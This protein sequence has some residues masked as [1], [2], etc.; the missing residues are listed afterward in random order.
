MLNTF[1]DLDICYILD[2]LGFEPNQIGAV[3]GSSSIPLLCLQ[4]VLFPN[5]VRR[6]GAKKVSKHWCILFTIS[7]G[8][9]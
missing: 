4:F 1:A 7:K 8:V 6:F 2:G 3:L 9:R 5:L